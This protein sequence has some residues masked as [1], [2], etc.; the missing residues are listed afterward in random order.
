MSSLS[1]ERGERKEVGRKNRKGPA[2]K[3]EEKGGQALKSHVVGLGGLP[4]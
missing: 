3:R 2:S 4:S 1:V